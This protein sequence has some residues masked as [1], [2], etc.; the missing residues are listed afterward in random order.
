MNHFQ[1]LRG[2][3]LH[4]HRHGGQRKYRGLS[5]GE[6]KSILVWSLMFFPLLDAGV[7]VSAGLQLWGE[8]RVQGKQ[9]RAGV[10]LHL[11][12]EALPA[13]TQLYRQHG[14]LFLGC[15]FS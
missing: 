14:Q 15:S 4:R 1:H 8:L 2:E 11:E 13:D 3:F 7:S 5:G 12:T 10:E 6:S 9:D